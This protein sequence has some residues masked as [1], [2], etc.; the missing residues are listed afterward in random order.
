[1]WTFKIS[2]F[3]FADNLQ[4]FS[5]LVICQKLFVEF[6]INDQ[7]SIW[8]WQQPSLNGHLDYAFCLTFGLKFCSLLFKSIN[9]NINLWTTTTKIG[10]DKF[11][12]AFIAFIYKLFKVEGF[13]F[14]IPNWWTTM[15]K[16]DWH[17]YHNLSSSNMWHHL[18]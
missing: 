13:W 2:E 12:A 8:Q 6:S 14:K 17:F 3:W 15:V 4:F 18:L 10:T 1:M 11:K 7:P 5:C 9:I 16:P